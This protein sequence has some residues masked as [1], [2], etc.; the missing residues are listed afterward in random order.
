M[1]CSWNCY[2]PYSYEGLVSNEKAS[3]MTVAHERPLHWINQTH[4]KLC[5]NPCT[6]KFFA[7]VFKFTKNI[8][9]IHFLHFVFVDCCV[10]AFVAALAYFLLLWCS[11]GCVSSKRTLSIFGPLRTLGE[12]SWACDAKNTVLICYHE[13]EQY[14]WRHC[15]LPESIWPTQ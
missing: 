1:I 13:M 5:M 6:S 4:S 14:W 9:F 11:C 15:N 7:Y 8:V 12:H 2:P 10:I 3:Q